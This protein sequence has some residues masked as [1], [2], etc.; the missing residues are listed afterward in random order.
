MREREGERE[1]WMRVDCRWGVG[2][3]LVCFIPLAPPITV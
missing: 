2:D 1:Q 3:V